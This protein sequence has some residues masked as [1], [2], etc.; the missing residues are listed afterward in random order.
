MARKSAL[1]TTKLH[2]SNR[3]GEQPFPNILCKRLVI[4]VMGPILA[5]LLS[6]GEIESLSRNLLWKARQGSVCTRKVGGRRT[7]FQA[8]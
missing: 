1:E 8:S 5:H 4:K 7:L 3:L 6:K 2:S